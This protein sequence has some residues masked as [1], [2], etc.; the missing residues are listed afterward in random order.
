MSST[1][2]EDSTRRLIRAWLAEYLR[3]PNTDPITDWVNTP[4]GRLAQKL[5][6]SPDDTLLRQWA[7]SRPKD[8]VLHRYQ[9]ALLHITRELADAKLSRSDGLV[10][11]LESERADLLDVI[12]EMEGRQILEQHPNAMRDEPLAS[13]VKL[14]EADADIREALAE[15]VV[16]TLPLDRLEALAAHLDKPK[17]E[18]AEEKATAARE[19]RR[20]LLGDQQ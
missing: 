6:A 13:F 3:D 20:I 5:A 1:F 12:A 15:Y 9:M 7:A 17:P 10:A 11:E 4:D 8:G 16:N 14:V 2:D 19:R 18:T